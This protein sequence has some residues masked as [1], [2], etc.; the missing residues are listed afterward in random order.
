MKILV[1][2][3][4]GAGRRKFKC[5]YCK[6]T[7]YKIKSRF[8]MGKGRFEFCGVI[9][10]NNAQRIGGILAPKHAGKTTKY[11]L[12]AL[13]ALPNL[14]NRCGYKKLKY[15]LQVHHRDEDRTHND[16]KNLEILC[17]NCHQAHH[18]RKR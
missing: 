6:V 2:D 13:R 10:K 18:M 11:R 3:K 9:C 1:H 12:K 15:I 16:I 8:K 4:A 14:C 17:P 7:K 5:A